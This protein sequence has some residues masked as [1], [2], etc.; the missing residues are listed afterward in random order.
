MQL[1]KKHLKNI[2]VLF[3][4]VYFPISIHASV[5]CLYN[6]QVYRNKP[7]IFNW[8]WSNPISF[9]CPDN[10]SI[11]TLYAKLDPGV[12]SSCN[13]GLFSAGKEVSYQIS[14]CPIDD[15]IP[16]L[17]F[18]ISGLGFF[19]LRRNKNLIPAIR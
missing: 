1:F 15:Y 12:G 3:G 4:L 13:V 6:G 7:T 14:N 2:L 9:T 17:I 16:F 8:Y 5:G 19:Y 11:N 18:T 10:A